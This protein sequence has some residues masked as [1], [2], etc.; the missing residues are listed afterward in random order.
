MCVNRLRRTR[1]YLHD[2]DS[3]AS[4]KRRGLGN[5]GSIAVIGA[6]YL[7]VIGAGLPQNFTLDSRA[8]SCSLE[9]AFSSRLK[10]ICTLDLIEMSI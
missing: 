8:G 4:D 7:L 6:A 2:R 10:Q 5:L 3:S 1:G 9:S